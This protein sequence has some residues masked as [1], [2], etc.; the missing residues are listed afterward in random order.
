VVY[1]I[2]SGEVAIIKN[3]PPGAATKYVPIAR[4][5]AA[6]CSAKQH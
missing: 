1:L 3:A 4:P 6:T 2:E 5:K